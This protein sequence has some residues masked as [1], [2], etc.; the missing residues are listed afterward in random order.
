VPAIQ[1]L[2]RGL[3]R[4]VKRWAPRTYEVAWKTADPVRKRV[5]RILWSRFFTREIRN[6]RLDALFGGYCGGETSSRFPDSGAFATQSMQYDELDRLFDPARGGVAITPSDVLVDVGC[7]KGRVLNFWLHQGLTNR[8]VGL[9]LDPDVAS[10]TA[11]RLRSY[12]NVV[13]E[14]GDA[15]ERLPP[16]GTLF[17]LFNPFDRP[18]WERF[19]AA[20]E[21]RCRAGSRPRLLYYNTMFVDVFER[22]SAWRVTGLAART[23]C[24]AAL[25]EYVG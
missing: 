19:K 8:I 25:I 1:R 4:V 16:D 12:P 20:L 21:E 2:V 22:D 13:V 11:A 15:I 9:E 23:F 10:T 3:K 17:F 7:G 14:A 18:V 6:R 5:R 24:P